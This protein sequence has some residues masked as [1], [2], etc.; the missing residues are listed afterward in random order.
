MAGSPRRCGQL[1]PVVACVRQEK[2]ELLDGF[3]RWSAPE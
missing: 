1:A 2:L 3:K